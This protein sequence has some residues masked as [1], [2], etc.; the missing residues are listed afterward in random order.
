MAILLKD[1]STLYGDIH[2][3]NKK[4]KRKLPTS[5]YQ[6]LEFDETVINIILMYFI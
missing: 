4:A 3:L 1:I 6:T 5:E 2:S